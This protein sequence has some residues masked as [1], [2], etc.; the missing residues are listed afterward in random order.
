M[1]RILKRACRILERVFDSQGVFGVADLR[2][3]SYFVGFLKPRPK[4]T[5]GYDAG[6]AFIP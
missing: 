4:L 6:L 2:P 5:F 1:Q 3:E